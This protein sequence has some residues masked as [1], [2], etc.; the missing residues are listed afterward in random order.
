[1]ANNDFIKS[2]SDDYL[3]CNILLY[4]LILKDLKETTLKATVE[5]RQSFL[6]A[7]LS[8]SCQYQPARQ[9][10]ATSALLF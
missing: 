10:D 9:L 4:R 1:L 7:A 5:K 6:T 3:C 8:R 2:K